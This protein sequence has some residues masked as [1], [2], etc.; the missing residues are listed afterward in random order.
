MNLSRRSFLNST[1][2][3][4]AV[5]ASIPAI[6]SSC[7]SPEEKKERLLNPDDTILFQG[8]SLT[9]GFR[10]YEY[11]YEPNIP[12][13]LGE[14]FVRICAGALLSEF[15]EKNLKIFNL[16]ISG[17]TVGALLGRWENDCIKLKPDVLNLLV[18]VNDFYFRYWKMSEGSAEIYERE[19]RRLLSITK[20]KLPDI[21]IVICEP[22]AFT[23][24]GEKVTDQWFPAFDEYREVAGLMAK[25]F[26]TIF[27]PYHSIFERA[28]EKA[29]I[30]YWM[31]DGIHPGVAGYY[32]MAETWLKYFIQ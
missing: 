10:K 11:G 22:F 9:E 5:L 2:I 19:Y 12:Q 21:K 3:N 30:E 17:N 4:T 24:D 28:C 1:A 29:P 16:G 15:C 32:V 13:A 8:D 20:E 7:I 27:I 31:P 18:G 26:E 25:E 23:T 14:G 6:V